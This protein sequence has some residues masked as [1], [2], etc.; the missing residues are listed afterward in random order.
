MVA[1]TGERVQTRDIGGWI[2]RGSVSKVLTSPVVHLLEHQKQQGLGQASR[3]GYC[4][5]GRV[6]T[7]CVEARQDET[8]G[9]RDIQCVWPLLAHLQQSRTISLFITA[10]TV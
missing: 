4:L 8:G 2:S 7:Q 10:E 9:M 6:P 1:A 3:Q 5:R